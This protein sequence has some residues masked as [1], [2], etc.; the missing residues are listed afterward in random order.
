MNITRR[1]IAILFLLGFVLPLAYAQWNTG[2]GYGGYSTS[3]TSSASTSYNTSS[4]STASSNTSSSSTVSA[5]PVATF[6]AISENNIIVNAIAGG[7][8]SLPGITEVIAPGTY[9]L[10]GNKTV[11]SYNF[12]LILFSTKNVPSPSSNGTLTPSGAFAYAI[13]GQI[14]TAITMVNSTGSPKPVT[15]F[16]AG[17]PSTSTTWTF[18]GGTFNGTSYTGGKYAFADTW[19]QVNSTTMVNTQFIKPV[20]WVFEAVK[21]PAPATTQPATSKTPAPSTSAPSS[22]GTSPLVYV[23][24]AVVVI[25]VIA[26]LYTR[27]KK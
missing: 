25:A 10:I 16:V 3:N 2:S 11:G 8:V 13:N 21:A 12:S 18:L 15:T 23:V 4:T 24:V 6:Q 27:S 1:S 19:K 5:V 22:P 20:M 7:S 14:T 17:S 26:Y 9:A